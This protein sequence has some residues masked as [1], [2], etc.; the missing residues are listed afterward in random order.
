MSLNVKIIKLLKISVGSMLTFAFQNC[1]S[2]QFSL[3]SFNSIPNTLLYNWWSTFLPAILKRIVLALNSILVYLSFLLINPKPSL[4]LFLALKSGT[5]QKVA[6]FF[7]IYVFL[8]NIKLL[9]SWNDISKL[10]LHRS[11]WNNTHSNLRK[12]FFRLFVIYL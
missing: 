5:P 10:R 8:S 1:R 9:N 2:L 3:I 11:T 6:P 7:Q 4:I 12:K